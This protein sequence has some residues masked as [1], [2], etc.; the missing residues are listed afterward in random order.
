[1]GVEKVTIGECTLYRGDC[2]EV[3]PTLEPVDA[4]VT[5]PPYGIGYASSR[6]TRLGGGPR[7]NKASFGADVLDTS[8]LTDAYRV[9]RPD[10]PVYVF[11]R[12][13]VLNEWKQAIEA[14][15][16]VVV[17]RLV[18]D[19]AHWKMGDLRY[20]GSQLEDVLF[21]RK[22][23]P[24]MHYQKRRGNILRYSSSWLPEGQ[25]DHPT[26]KPERLMADYILDG[27]QDG[28]AVLDPFMGSGT[29][30]VACVKTGR[31]FIGIEID[32]AHFATACRRIESAYAESPL[33]TTKEG[34]A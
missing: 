6:T 29:T 30:G 33:L 5:D 20:Y 31:K 13:D 12:W 4:V 16:F 9:L 7:K 21:C 28:D 32:P 27:T 34:A 14:A 10:T 18:W 24:T 8:W 2:L 17:Q 3:L 1:M 25:Y 26:Q 11:T 15:G 23:T 22:G 19:K